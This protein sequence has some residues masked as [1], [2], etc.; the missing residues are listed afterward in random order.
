MHCYNELILS[1][2]T[3][4]YIATWHTS[5]ILL[6]AITNPFRQLNYEPSSKI[7]EFKNYKCARFLAARQPANM[8]ISIASTL[9]WPCLIKVEMCAETWISDTS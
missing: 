4:D 7:I 5:M 8:I 1:L 3:K 6:A 2:H 9:S